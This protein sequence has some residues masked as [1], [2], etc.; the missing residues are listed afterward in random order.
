[1]MLVRKDGEQLTVGMT[2][3]T[4]AGSDGKIVGL[5]PPKD[6]E[7]GMIDVQFPLS[8]WPTRLYHTAINAEWR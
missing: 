4:M 2:V 3:T 1:M 8:P 5:F 6:G 7:L